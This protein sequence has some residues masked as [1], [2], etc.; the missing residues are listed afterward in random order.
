MTLTPEEGRTV[1][2]SDDIK[3]PITTLDQRG[4]NL[5]VSPVINMS[6]GV[7]FGVHLL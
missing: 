6:V 2:T 7:N 5:Q 1:V 4:A 3:Q